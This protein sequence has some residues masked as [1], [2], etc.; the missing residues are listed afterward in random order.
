MAAKTVKGTVQVVPPTAVVDRGRISH[1]DD[2]ELSYARVELAQMQKAAEEGAP[3]DM[4]RFRTLIEQLDAGLMAI[5][6]SVP[7]DW[8]VE[9]GSFGADNWIKQLRSDRYRELQ[10][11]AQEEAPGKKER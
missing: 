3:L 5:T 1:G 9:G 8:F 4:A 2:M 10:V 6:V 11:L 7:A